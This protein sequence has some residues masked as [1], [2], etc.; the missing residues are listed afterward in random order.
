MDATGATSSTASSGSRRW[1]GS[2]PRGRW[3]DS[4]TSGRS[5]RWYYCG[6]SQRI[7]EGRVGGLWL[8]VAIVEQR[9]ALTREGAGNPGVRLSDTPDGDIVAA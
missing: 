1:R 3:R 8:V 6:A 9:L 2:C 5:W 7:Q 4:S